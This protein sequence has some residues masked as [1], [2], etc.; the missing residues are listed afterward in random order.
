VR[1]VRMNVPEGYAYGLFQPP[2][3]CGVGACGACLVR[4]GG[5]DVAACVDGPAFDLSTTIKAE[6]A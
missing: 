4:S 5:E 1:R 3:P 2:M 6:G